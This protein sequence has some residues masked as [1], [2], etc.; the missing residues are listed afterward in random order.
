MN[1]EEKEMLIRVLK[2]AVKHE[3]RLDEYEEALRELIPLVV[4]RVRLIP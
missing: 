3:E 1:V 2:M 4:D